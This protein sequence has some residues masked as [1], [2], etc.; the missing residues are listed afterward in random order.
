MS[1][2]YNL[3]SQPQI[4]A[5]LNLF[6]KELDHGVDLAIE[7][8]QIPA[9]TFAEKQRANFVESHFSRLNLQDVYQD[10]LGNVYGRI[11]GKNQSGPPVIVSAHTDTV[12]PMETD[13][14]VSRKRDRVYGPSI[15]D[16]SMGV[17]AL[18]WLGSTLTSQQITPNQDLWFVANVAEEGLGD[19][20]GIRAVVNRFGKESYYIVIEG[21]SFGHLIHRG[22][23][24][25]RLEIKVTANGGHSWADFG[26]SSAIHMLGKIIGQIDQ[27][28]VPRQPKTTY[29]V[30]VIE[31]GT[32]INTIASS[33][34][35][36]LD[37]RSENS[38]ELNILVDRVHRII[39]KNNHHGGVR[40]HVNQIGDRPPG[41]LD[42]N[43]QLLQWAMDAL[44]TVKSPKIELGAS[45]TD[46]NIPLSIGAPAICI[47]I[48]NSGNVHRTD[49]FLDTDLVPKG[50]GQLLL[51][52]LAVAGY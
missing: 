41:T 1:Y 49:E 16:N 18:L 10:E 5:A 44:R 36:L 21:G 8:Q 17:A 25:K 11:P 38:N 22:I 37:L 42:T 13:L 27:I 12:F 26:E 33:A 6:S 23:G 34:R 31:G 20:K 51:L 7:I 46:A 50:M 3:S 28:P 4:Q 2:I 40:I 47:G 32:S 9:P 39:K 24:V 43:H 29:N 15:A 35:L 45:S 14:T 48:G 30:G 19:L 52:T